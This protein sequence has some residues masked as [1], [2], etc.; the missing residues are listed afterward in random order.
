MMLVH[1]FTHHRRQFTEVRATG[2]NVGRNMQASMT[3]VRPARP[4]QASALPLQLELPFITSVTLDFNDDMSKY[5]GYKF[6]N[7]EAV[8]PEL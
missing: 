7:R 1:M 6:G 8:P 3:K 5:S 4:G 2:M